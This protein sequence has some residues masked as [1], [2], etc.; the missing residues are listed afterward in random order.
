MNCKILGW[1]EDLYNDTNQLYIS[2]VTEYEAKIA[3]INLQYLSKN[4]PPIDIQ[5]EENIIIF[6]ISRKIKINKSIM[7]RKILELLLKLN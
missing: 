5:S 4:I 1:K 3:E 2:A 6:G 7:E